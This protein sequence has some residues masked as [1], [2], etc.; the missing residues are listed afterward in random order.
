MT[1]LGFYHARPIMR[2][3]LMIHLQAYP[4]IVLHESVNVL[5][6]EFSPHDLID[7]A[8]SVRS[9]LSAAKKG[10]REIGIEF[11]VVWGAG[12]RLIL[13]FKDQKPPCP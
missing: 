1:P 9:H 11:K 2:N 10:L 13:N 4:H 12:Y 6:E 3:L 7:P 5:Y 8:D